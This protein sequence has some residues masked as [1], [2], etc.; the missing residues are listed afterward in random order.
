MRRWRSTESVAGYGDAITY[1]VAARNDACTPHPTPRLGWAV[2]D[3]SEYVVQIAIWLKLCTPKVV[4]LTRINVF[5][6]RIRGPSVYNIPFVSCSCRC[7]NSPQT[8]DHQHAQQWSTLFAAHQQRDFASW[9]VLPQTVPGTANIGS[10]DGSASDFDAMDGRL[11][12]ARCPQ[13]ISG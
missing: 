11:Y 3:L 7:C 13:Q 4:L 1:V 5:V 6:L 9:T 2:C 8:S 10:P 12:G